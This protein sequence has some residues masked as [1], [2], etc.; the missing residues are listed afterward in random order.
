[1]EAVAR[2]NV[3]SDGTVMVSD[4]SPMKV[5]APPTRKLSSNV[6]SST[7]QSQVSIPSCLFEVMD[8]GGDL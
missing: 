8:S 3:Q 6:L 4:S 5:E 7:I 1:M 2:P